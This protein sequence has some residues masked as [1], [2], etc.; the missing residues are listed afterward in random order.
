MPLNEIAFLPD[1]KRVKINDSNTVLEAVK[2]AGV[3]LVTICGGKGTCGKCKVKI[4]P[5]MFSPPLTENEKKFL[6]PLEKTEGIR[7]ACQI[8]AA[9]NHLVVQIPEYSRTGKQRLQVEGIKTAAEPDLMVKKYYL[10][11]PEPSLEDPRSD[12]DRIIHELNKKHKITGVT[13]FPDLLMNIAAL[14]RQSNWQIT[15]TVWND[16][17]IIAIEPGNTTN[18]IFGIALDIGTTKL[19]AYLLDMIRGEVLAVDSAMNPQ[20]PFGED[21][22]SRINYVSS[23]D[24]AQN[25]PELQQILVKQI[26]GLIDFLCEKSA[27]SVE[28][29][30]EMTAVGN[31]AMHHI[32]LNLNPK[33]LALAPYAPVIRGGINLKPKQVGLKINPTGNLY[34]LPV[35]AGFN[36]SDNVAVLLA[37]EIYKRSELCLA[38]DIGTN[39]EVALGNKDQLLVCSCASGPAFEGASIK[40][41]MRAASGAIEHI[42]IDPSTLKC[43]YKT[44][45][46]LPPRGICGSAIVDVIAELLK[47]GIIDVSGRMD[48]SIQSPYFREGSDGYEFILAPASE[49]ANGMDIVITQK[50]IRQ[51]LLA[52][53]AMHTG[54][55]LLMDE[56]GITEKDIDKVFIAGAF[57]NYIDVANA[58]FIGMYPEIDLTK[59]TLVGN[60]AGT[61]A[62]MTLLS[63]KMRTLAET[64]SQQTKYVELAIKKNFQSVYLNSTFI[65]YADLSKYPETSYFLKKVGRFPLK[66]PHIF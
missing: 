27:V 5:T 12:V 65:P 31:T 15:V 28:E 6:I 32:F 18:R 23:P 55:Q 38:L 10:Q 46:S 56:L 62:R 14:L 4:D 33:Y 16:T 29:I 42:Q 57:G 53:A 44:I 47:A 24:K 8:K 52:K 43:S 7:L 58:R 61:G 36:G 49:T 35:I 25:S 54:T 1:G 59:V 40:F 2:L 63:K 19:A 21:I 20:I 66:L 22:I 41:G 37:T 3:D 11:P 39:T 60:A 17:Q 50:D 64:I 48:K 13:I 9:K 26:N 51:I 45:D 30:Y 34:C